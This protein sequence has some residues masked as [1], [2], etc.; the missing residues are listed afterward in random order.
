VAVYLFDSLEEAIELHND[1]PYGLVASVFSRK[2]SHFSEMVKRL[3]VG[4]LYWNR[5]TIGAPS[6]LPFGGLK[7]SGNHFPGGLFSSYYC[8]YPL[9]VVE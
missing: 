4:N 9:A 1:C 8:T 3:E 7:A 5:A 2:K 6:R